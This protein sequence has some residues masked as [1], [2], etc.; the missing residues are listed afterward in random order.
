ML[1][2]KSFPIPFAGR[3]HTFAILFAKIIHPIAGQNLLASLDRFG[4][5]ELDSEAFPEKH[6]VI[7]T[8]VIDESGRSTEH[9]ELA[10]RVDD[11]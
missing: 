8:V 4:H 3:A 10:P 6:S 5:F 7:V 1:R 11:V 9:L 2:V